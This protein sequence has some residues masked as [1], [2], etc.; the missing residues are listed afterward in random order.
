MRQKLLQ[1]QEGGDSDGENSDDL[2]GDEDDDAIAGPTIVVPDREGEESD[3]ETHGKYR[4]A[5]K[6]EDDFQV[7]N[8]DKAS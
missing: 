1:A 8:R 5:S 7:I 2:F 4:G 6:I 3:Q